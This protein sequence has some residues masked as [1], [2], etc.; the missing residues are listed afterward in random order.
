MHLI[1]TAGRWGT[2]KKERKKERK[3]VCIFGADRKS[4]SGSTIYFDWLKFQ[5]SPING[6]QGTYI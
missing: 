1:F 5:N 3:K 2:I 4:G 6:N